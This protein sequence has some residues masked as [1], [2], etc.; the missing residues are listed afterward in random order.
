[1]PERPGTVHARALFESESLMEW[2]KWFK[3]YHKAVE[4][5]A[6]K[7][8]QTNLIDLDSFVYNELKEA[9]LAR[10]PPH[11]KLS[12]LSDLMKWKLIRGKFRPLQKLVDSN[13]ESAVNTHTEEGLK[14]LKDGNWIK[15]I[16]AFSKLKGIGVA[17]ASAIGSVFC[18]E[19]CPFM[20]DE[21]IECVSVK[22]DYTMKIY[23]ELQE[24]LVRKA[25]AIGSGW[26]AEMVSKAL[27]SC[28]MLHDDISEPTDVEPIKEDTTT[29]LQ[30][31]KEKDASQPS[32][33]QR[34]K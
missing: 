10:T 28:A 26:N 14:L 3:L 13:S 32:K 27:W 8:K 15:A 18:P 19:L 33:R 4:T 21:V 11:M 24:Q 9:A 6:K 30:A 31:D 5:V 7:K 25:A 2:E 1:M 23:K 17:T 12:E 20:A 34:K 22:R 29:E 16:D